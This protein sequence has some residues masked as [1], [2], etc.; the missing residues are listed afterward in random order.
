[1]KKILI[2]LLIVIPLILLMLAFFS[3]L[4]YDKTNNT[5]NM[6]MN[7][8]IITDYD[9]NEYTTV[10]IGNQI[11]MTK[12]LT[13]S[14]YN[15]G[16]SIEGIS[17]YD[18]KESN[19]EKYGRLYQWEAIKN[20]AGLCPAGWHVATDEEWK[21]LEA[22]LGMSKSETDGTGWRKTFNESKKL[23]KFGRVYFRSKKE[24]TEINIS[25]FSAVPSGA[26]T[27]RDLILP[28]WGGGRYAD[29]W[30]ATESSSS[31]AWNRSLVWIPIHPGSD[32]VF[33]GKLNKEF[34]FSIRCVKD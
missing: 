2:M 21:E 22:T 29:Y 7:N 33:R 26:R 34:G 11:W 17:V 18:N 30:T 28:F 25:G 1:M 4:G 12:N 6:D 10:K 3:D 20:P 8:K 15:D 9:G 27:R 19:I 31:E 23:K 5:S 24:Q 14:H 13:T 32:K 16:T